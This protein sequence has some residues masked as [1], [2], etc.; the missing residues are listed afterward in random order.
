MASMWETKLA[1]QREEVAA[2]A[3][4]T[5]SKPVSD[6]NALSKSINENTASNPDSNSDSTPSPTKPKKS[7][8]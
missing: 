3:I 8:V 2:T 6:V 4:P 1:K 7:K 5:Y